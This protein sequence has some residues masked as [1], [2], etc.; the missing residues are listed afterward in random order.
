MLAKNIR[1]FWLISLV[2]NVYKLLA[3]VLVNSFKRGSSEIV[4]GL[5]EHFYLTGDRFLSMYSALTKICCQI[6]ITPWYCLLYNCVL[7]RNDVISPTNLSMQIDCIY[8]NFHFL[9]VFNDGSDF[10][11][12]L[13][14]RYWLKRE[15]EFVGVALSKRG[16][17]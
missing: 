17:K 12:P 16:F 11:I 5:T 7:F 13:R 15:L 1:D 10:Y 2:G 8:L 9:A 3:K 4:V 6:D 14:C